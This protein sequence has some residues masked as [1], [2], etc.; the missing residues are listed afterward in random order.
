MPLLN[1]ICC[2]AHRDC[3]LNNIEEYLKKKQYKED[4]K[5]E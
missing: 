3:I 5:Y 4:Y 1:L 2:E